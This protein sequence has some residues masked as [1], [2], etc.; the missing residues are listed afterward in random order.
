M[1]YLQWVLNDIQCDR[2]ATTSGLAEVCLFAVVDGV[3]LIVSS[4]LIDFRRKLVR[5]GR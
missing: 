3:L 1:I 5:H 4:V 2:G